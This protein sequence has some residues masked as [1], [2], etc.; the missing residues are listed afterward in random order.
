MIIGSQY[1]VPEVRS[2]APWAAS[3]MAALGT[4]VSTSTRTERSVEEGGGVGVMVAPSEW[5]G[6]SAECSWEDGHVASMVS[7]GMAASAG[8]MGDLRWKGSA[9]ACGSVW[10]WLCAGGV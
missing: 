7:E 1:E 6:L 2:I 8:G 10:L 5:E 9:C 3:E 4:P